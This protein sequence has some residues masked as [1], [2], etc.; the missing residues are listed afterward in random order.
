MRRS[1]RFTG[2]EGS[3]SLEFITVG[4]I[5][6]VPL[7]YLVVALG[8]IEAG[9]FGVE[10]AA[11]QGARVFVQS[12]TG[13]DAAANAGVAIGDALADYGLSPAQATVR[14]TC[15]PHPRDCLARRGFVSVRVSASVPL[16]LVPAVVTSKLP[17][18]VP[19][20]ATATQQVSR[21]WGAG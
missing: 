12:E 11:R 14:V 15:A 16:P 1:R 18:S 3:A 13:R 2:D 17:L 19:L 4:M 6:L 8:S 10:G 7:V 9:S 21:F 5:L 20:E